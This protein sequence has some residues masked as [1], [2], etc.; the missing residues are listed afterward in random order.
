[1]LQSN[2]SIHNRPTISSRKSVLNDIPISCSRRFMRCMFTATEGCTLCS[3]FVSFP[4]RERNPNR[5]QKLLCGQQVDAPCEFCGPSR[6]N[7]AEDKAW[8]KV[9]CLRRG[10]GCGLSHALLYIVNTELPFCSQVS[11]GFIPPF[12]S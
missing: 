7:S 8:S 6:P 9:R 11:A 12:S 2:I 1:M 3:L 4:G 5:T 10:L